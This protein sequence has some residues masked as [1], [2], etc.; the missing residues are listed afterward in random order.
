M[1][2]NDCEGEK[3]WGKN[4]GRLIVVT[5]MLTKQLV[6]K[7]TESCSDA[8]E[9][10]AKV[11]EESKGRLDFQGVPSLDNDTWGTWFYS[12]NGLYRW[13]VTEMSYSGR[14]RLFTL[15]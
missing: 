3:A 7:S 2:L 6:C 5:L 13:V 1:S 9:H 10:S 11:L 14:S 15:V 8:S 4:R 12:H